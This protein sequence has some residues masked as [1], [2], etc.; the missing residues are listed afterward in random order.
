[1]LIELDDDGVRREGEFRYYKEHLKSLR[2]LTVFYLL[3]LLTFL[4][5]PY[6]VMGILGMIPVIFRIRLDRKATQA[7]KEFLQE[8]KL[9]L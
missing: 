8:Q 5:F 4:P 2:R 3:F 9:K 7:G 1:M 6:S